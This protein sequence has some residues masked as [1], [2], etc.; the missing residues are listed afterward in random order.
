MLVRACAA[1]F[2]GADGPAEVFR[3]V[4]TSQWA[5]LAG[6]GPASAAQASGSRCLH[7]TF[8]VF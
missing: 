3:S 1:V 7:H 6:L 5:R 8:G 2:D 4:G